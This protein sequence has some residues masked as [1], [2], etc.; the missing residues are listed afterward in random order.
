MLCSFTFTTFVSAFM[1]FPTMPFRILSLGGTKSEAGL[2]L[3]FLTFASAFSAPLGGALADRIGKRPVLLMSSTAIFF[4]VLAYAFAQ[5][6]YLILAIAIP[7]GVF[8]S[9]LL[10]SSGALIS[11]IIPP[12]RR[13]EGIGYW[14]LASVVAIAVAPTMGLFLF[15]FGWLPLCGL[16]AALAIGMFAIAFRISD[17][18]V[19]SKW[20]LSRLFSGGLVEKGVFVL[21][22]SLFLY[23]FGYGGVTSFVSVYAQESGVRWR[24]IYFVVFSI[25]VLATRPY[26]GRL[27]DRK[28]PVRVLIPLL[29]MTSAGFAILSIGGTLP[30]LVASAVIFGTGFG[31]AYPVFAAYMLSRV[32]PER[33]GAA[34]GSILLAFDTGIG[35]GSML[36]GRIIEEYGYRPAF[37]LSATLALGAIPYFLIARRSLRQFR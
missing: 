18:S 7:H 29:G 34:F 31:S 23:S 9:A 25:T 11:D 30:Y 5:S 28:G 21:A 2:F 16:M 15:R 8:W 3:G 4:F 22:I 37:A 17:R 36:L 19:P 32:A 6:L 26:F 35:A 12:A 20:M 14:G 27:S 10:A 1:L 13:A 24:G 33:R